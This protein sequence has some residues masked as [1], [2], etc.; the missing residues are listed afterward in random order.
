MGKYFFNKR[1]KQTVNTED[2]YAL[3]IRGKHNGPLIISRG[4]I[5][6]AIICSLIIT[7]IFQKEKTSNYTPVIS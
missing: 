1:I 4:Y 2:T 6:T 3:R 7:K 5:I